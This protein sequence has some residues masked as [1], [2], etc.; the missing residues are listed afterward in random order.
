LKRI[1]LFS[2]AFSIR[3]ATH[4]ANG[5]Y[6]PFEIQSTASLYQLRLAVAEKLD[7]FP[8]NLILGYRLDSD[9][10]KM[11]S[12]SIQTENELQ[13]F[14]ERMRP[15]LVPPR[16]ANGKP[17]TRIPKSTIV[18]F[19]ACGSGVTPD[20]ETIHSNKRTPVSHHLYRLCQLII[21]LCFIGYITI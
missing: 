14:I 2:L 17:S 20:E 3:C 9:K 15:L 21:T 6:A 13:M 16:L 18:Y 8:D 10:A 5:T 12:T 19:D 4:H 11:G 7:C 1:Y